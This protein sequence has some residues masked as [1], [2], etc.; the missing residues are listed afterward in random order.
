[1]A[2][3]YLLNRIETILSHQR[4][5]RFAY[6]RRK[7]ASFVLLCG[8]NVLD[9]SA[10]SRRILGSFTQPSSLLFVWV[11]VTKDSKDMLQ[12]IYLNTLIPMLCVL[13]CIPQKNQLLEWHN[14]TNSMIE[15][16]LCSS[17]TEHY[18]NHTDFD[19][20]I[21]RCS[22]F[23]YRNVCIVQAHPWQHLIN[24]RG[25]MIRSAVK[26]QALTIEYL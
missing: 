21:V 25:K 2:E 15:S 6:S 17:H 13:L 11:D 16:K 22:F 24:G 8:I 18:P 9:P 5:Y 14:T 3:I 7:W 26:M 19:T 10:C 1:M 4:C 20:N 12:S 23:A